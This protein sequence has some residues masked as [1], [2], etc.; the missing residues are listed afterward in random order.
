MLPT[1]DQ[2]SFPKSNVI[3]FF[4]ETAPVQSYGRTQYPT[5]APYPYRTATI[6]S[7]TRTTN[8]FLENRNWSWF[9]RSLSVD[10]FWGTTYSKFFFIWRGSNL[11]ENILNLTDQ[12]ICS[13]RL[14]STLTIREWGPQQEFWRISVLFSLNFIIGRDDWAQL[15]T[16][17]KESRGSDAWAEWC[18]RQ[19]NEARV[20][21]L[22]SPLPTRFNHRPPFR[23]VPRPGFDSLFC[24]V[25]GGAP[26]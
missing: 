25:C 1:E 11:W 15:I 13:S 17:L 9:H 23:F 16:C 19:Q 6:Y 18:E 4:R 12:I 26:W 22:R 20:Q 24:V 14:T 10:T 8:C 21:A 7:Q 3:K 5:A 2:R